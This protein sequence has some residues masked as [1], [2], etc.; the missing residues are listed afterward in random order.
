MAPANWEGDTLVVKRTS[1]ARFA[2]QGNDLRIDRPPAVCVSDPF[3]AARM[4]SLP[5][6]QA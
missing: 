6:N 4:R 1:A 5:P 2:T 3:F